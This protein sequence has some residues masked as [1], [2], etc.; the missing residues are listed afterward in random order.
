MITRRVLLTA[1]AAAAL[2]PS[3]LAQ[4]A[5][6]L[7]GRWT[8][9]WS[10]AGDDLAVVV[11]FAGAPGAWTAT[12]DSDELQ[13]AAIPFS[14]VTLKEGKLG[15]MLRGDASTTA[16]DGVL[17][18]D[19]IAGEFT[20]GGIQG[21]FQLNRDLTPP[22]PVRTEEVVFRNGEVS[23]AGTLLRPAAPG[24]RPAIVF[25][26]GS[27]GEGRWASRWL[28]QRFAAAGFSA[29]IF[30]KRGVGQS[31][32]DWRQSGFEDLAEDAAAG[33]RLLRSRPDIDPARIGV[34]GHSQGGT[35][36]PLAAERAGGLA[37]VIASAAGGVD[38]A[39]MEVYSVANSIG[40][41]GLSAAEAKDARAYVRE[42]VEVAYHG[43]DRA[44]LDRMAA[45]FKG[46]SWYFDP[47]ATDDSYWALSR[48]IA[49]YDP[50]AHWARVRAP[51]L[52][53]FGARDE[54]VPQ[55]ESAAAIRAALARGGEADV[56][57]RI[58]PGAD[59]TFRLKAT[60]GGWP[61]RAGGYAETMIDWAR[62]KVG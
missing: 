25:L 12:F 46:R 28:A 18:G 61:K 55:S 42:L 47:P 2:P 51:V 15:L 17:V 54:R 30:D 4:D 48:R 29:L 20:E 19:I 60:E 24:R 57:L 40:V 45:R 41:A 37:F 39:A 3:A 33:V 8:G 31:T 49:G 52:L 14:E 59:H 11:T 10:K 22:A 5:P 26:H 32:G 36:A 1:V 27:G 44:G 21:A 7:A 13:A 50:A 38:P 6:G 62:S 56:T 16:F 58:F 43:R 53:L 35:I 9:I 23:L 34:Y